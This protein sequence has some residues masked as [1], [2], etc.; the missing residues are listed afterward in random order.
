MSLE[1]SENHLEFHLEFYNFL[2][3]NDELWNL[4][5]ELHNDEIEGNV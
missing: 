4:S 1:L 2:P 5:F 3:H